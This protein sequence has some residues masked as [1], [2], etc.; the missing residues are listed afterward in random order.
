MCAQRSAIIEC[1]AGFMRDLTQIIDAARAFRR[2]WN[3]AGTKIAFAEECG[4][5]AAINVTAREHF[6][7]F[8]AI[9]VGQIDGFTHFMIHPKGE[10]ICVLLQLVL[11]VEEDGVEIKTV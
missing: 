7:R 6:S 8:V 1:E 5:K 10:A 2:E 11:T 4:A 3:E 9:D